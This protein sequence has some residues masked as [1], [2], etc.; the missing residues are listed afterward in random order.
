[1]KAHIKYVFLKDQY[2]VNLKLYWVF[3]FFHTIHVSEP[4]DFFEFEILKKNV[5]LEMQFDKNIF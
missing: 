1:M 2:Y 4:A 3:Q 5:M